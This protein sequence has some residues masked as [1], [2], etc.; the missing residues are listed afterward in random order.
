MYAWG[1]LFSGRE[2]TARLR[3]NNDPCVGLPCFKNEPQNIWRKRDATRCRMTWRAPNMQKNSRP[4]AR[5]RIRPVEI[6]NAHQVIKRVAAKQ[7][8]GAE[9]VMPFCDQVVVI[10]VSRIVRPEIIGTDWRYRHW[11]VRRVYAVGAIHDPAYFPSPP[12]RDPIP[13]A[14]FFANASAPHRT[15]KRA[16][17]ISRAPFSDHQIIGAGGH[18]RCPLFFALVSR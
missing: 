5:Q 13:L 16:P 6:E 1:Q 8:L 9:R 10:G 11:E 2:I 17:F 7:P 4:F 15:G 18:S 14:V 12:W 3:A